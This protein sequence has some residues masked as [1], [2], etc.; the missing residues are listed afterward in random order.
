[1]TDR[2]QFEA[3]FNSVRYRSKYAVDHPVTLAAWEAWQ[4]ARAAAPA[5]WGKRYKNLPELMTL[6][7]TGRMTGDEAMAELFKHLSSDPCA[8]A[9]AKGGSREAAWRAFAGEYEQVERLR[10]LLPVARTAL[11]KTMGAFAGTCAWHA[12]VADAI[13]RIDAE[14]GEKHD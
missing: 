8:A 7:K 5:V 3:W 6:W 2:E 10:A 4:A 9:P 12:D 1:M 14:L 13:A 11:Q